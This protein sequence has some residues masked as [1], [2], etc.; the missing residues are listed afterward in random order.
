MSL[1]RRYLPYHLYFIPCSSQF[2]H[3]SQLG[4]AFYFYKDLLFNGLCSE[5]CAY[6]NYH[7][8]AYN[9]HFILVY[10]VLLHM[11]QEDFD[12]IVSAEC[13]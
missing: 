4:Q 6:F 12:S 13:R 8:S 2:S 7:L 9:T 11:Q 5:G 3:L 1:H 10:F